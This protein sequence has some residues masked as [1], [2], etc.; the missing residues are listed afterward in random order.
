MLRIMFPAAPCAGSGQASPSRSSSG[1]RARLAARQI[2]LVVGI[3]VFLAIVY[4][5]TR[6]FFDSGGDVGLYQAYARRSSAPSRQLPRE[7]PPL[8]V[9]IFL[10][11]QTI[12]PQYYRLAFA[13]LAAAVTAVVV[14]TVDK[15]NRRGWWLILYLLLGAFGTVFFRYDIFVV[16]LT[17]GAFMAGRRHRWL[18][19]QALLALAVGLKLYAVVL[20]PLVVIWEWRVERRYPWRSAVGGA[21]AL[22]AAFG[23]MWFLASGEVA[24]MLRYHQH[25]P[26][27][28]ESVGASIVW[29]LGRPTAQFSF[30]SWNVRSSA[31]SEVIAS[32]SVLSIALLLGLY[33]LF[34][35]GRLSP[36]RA[37]ALALIILLT[38]SKVFSTQYLIWVL[39]FVALVEVASPGDGGA[40]QSLSQ[41]KGY[42]WL[43]VVVCL[44]TS[45]IY[46]VGLELFAIPDMAAL[47][48]PNWLMALVTTRNVLLIA[49]GLILLDN[50]RALPQW[51]PT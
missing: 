11:S 15:L 31:E 6:S 44:V 33:A 34:W 8:S 10:L 24:E 51:N 40:Q 29:A 36:A 21:V 32:M 5:P 7:Y 49:A 16:A 14:L 13:S 3:C 20:M 22:L 1:T 18:P 9:L 23:S 50:R 45:L 48:P 35:R 41:R 17:V 39:P 37:W 38:T 2:S 46:P 26:L 42:R 47:Y 30:G 25:R 28:F 19:S 4:E 43:W 12:N 27:E